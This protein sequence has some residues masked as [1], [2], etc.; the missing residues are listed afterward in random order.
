MEPP[1]TEEG[2][3]RMKPIIESGSQEFFTI[4][5][6][7]IRDDGDRREIS[8]TPAPCVPPHRTNF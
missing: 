7:A 6:Q 1:G 8:A 3:S 2:F 5:E 4:V